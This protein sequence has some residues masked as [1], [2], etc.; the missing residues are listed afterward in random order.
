MDRAVRDLNVNSDRL[1]AVTKEHLLF[2]FN[3]ASLSF[4]MSTDSA[5]SQSAACVSCSALESLNNHRDHLSFEAT[6]DF[7]L[8]KPNVARGVVVQ[9]GH[10]REGVFSL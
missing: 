3:G 8:F 7:I 6:A 10:S 2:S 5:A 9:D 4:V 1:L